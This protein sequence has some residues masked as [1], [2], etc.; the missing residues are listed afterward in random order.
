MI[1]YDN[2]VP[3]VNVYSLASHTGVQILPFLSFSNNWQPFSFLFFRTFWEV[4]RQNMFF[5]LLNVVAVVFWRHFT[6][7]FDAPKYFQRHIILC[8]I[9][10]N[11]FWHFLSYRAILVS[12]NASKDVSVD[13][14]LVFS[15][16]LR[17]TIYIF[18]YRIRGTKK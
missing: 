17:K 4:G 12:E 9:L 16:S 11:M 10:I 5:R 3:G 2:C 1:N 13:F 14:F 15:W 18:F 6:E 8:K 7:V